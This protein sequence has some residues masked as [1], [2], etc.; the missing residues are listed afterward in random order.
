MLPFA[1]GGPE[2]SIMK[3]LGIALVAFAAGMFAQSAASNFD[4]WW[5]PERRDGSRAC[6]PQAIPGER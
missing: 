4:K 2:D 1:R 5:T 3:K 6:K